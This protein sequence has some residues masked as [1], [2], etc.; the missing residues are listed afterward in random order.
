[1]VAPKNQ[2]QNL[3]STIK[4]K[5]CGALKSKDGILVTDIL[6]KP[7]QVKVVLG[8]FVSGDDDCGIP[9]FFYPVNPERNR[10]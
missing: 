2:F 10:I 6:W 9:L 7:Y 1:M 3:T 4:E 8:G 5:A